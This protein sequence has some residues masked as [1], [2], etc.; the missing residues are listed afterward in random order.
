ML[1]HPRLLAIEQDRIVPDQIDI[2]TEARRVRVLPI[3]EL[4]QH[5][6]QVHGILDDVKVLGDVHLDRID[7]VL[8]VD[9]RVMRP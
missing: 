9:A 3:L 5:R 1:L 2:R 6:L 8:E 7:R 4:V